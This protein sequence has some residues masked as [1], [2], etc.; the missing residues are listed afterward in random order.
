L[1]SAAAWLDEQAGKGVSP[2]A[3]VAGD[4]P[5]SRRVRQPGI[6]RNPLSEGLKHLAATVRRHGL[7]LDDLAQR[8]DFTAAANRLEA[9]AQGIE[10][11][12]VQRLPD[13]VYWIERLGKKDCPC[14]RADRS[15]FRITL[16]PRPSRSAPSP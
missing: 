15:L 11:W 13:S 10:D 7:G 4:V 14:R 8:Q 9:L 16:T 1:E 12:R 2:F 5:F 3:K 6:V